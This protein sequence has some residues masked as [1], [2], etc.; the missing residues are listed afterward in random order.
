MSV[1]L[2]IENIS[3]LVWVKGEKGGVAYIL[4]TSCCWVSGPR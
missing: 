4:R 2:R 3:G 1:C